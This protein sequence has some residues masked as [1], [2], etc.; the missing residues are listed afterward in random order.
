MYIH[1]YVNIYIFKHRTRYKG[2]LSAL[3][4]HP[5]RYIYINVSIPGYTLKRRFQL[6]NLCTYIHVCIFVYIDTHA[7]LAKRTQFDRTLPFTRHPLTHLKRFVARAKD[8][9]LPC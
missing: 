2:V 8:H 6:A 5:P 1:I 9:G 7:H 3:C 4:A